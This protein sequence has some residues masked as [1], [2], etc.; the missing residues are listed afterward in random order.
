MKKLIILW[1]IILLV[2]LPVASVVGCKPEPEQ[3]PPPS[4]E[5]APPEEGA[6]PEEAPPPPPPPPETKTYT[7]SEQG[8][9]VEYPKNWRQ[10]GLTG[11][12]DAIW[13]TAFEEPV[14]GIAPGVGIIKY[15][16]KGKTLEDFHNEMAEELVV[17][18]S[19]DVLAI[20]QVKING[21]D[22]YITTFTEESPEG[23]IKGKEM[24]ITKDHRI[25]YCVDCYSLLSD[26][27]RNEEDFDMIHNSFVIE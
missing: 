17:F 22:A 26:Y 19:R 23:T 5:V 2:L 16:M 13:K 27:D 6:P 24:T 21:L 15:D 4:E 1:T 25:A 12:T 7:N 11:Y 8:F 9:S 20:V 14:S 3:A 10:V 18:G